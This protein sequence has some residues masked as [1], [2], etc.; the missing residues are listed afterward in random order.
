[1]SPNSHFPHDRLPQPIDLPARF[2]NIHAHPKTQ[3]NDYAQPIDTIS[4]VSQLLEIFEDV[5][6]SDLCHYLYQLSTKG[7]D[8]KEVFQQTFCHFFDRYEFGF[9]KQH[10][11]LAL[12][13]QLVHHTTKDANY[14]HLLVHAFHTLQKEIQG[15][16]SFPYAPIKLKRLESSPNLLLEQY[17]GEADERSAL[18]AAKMVLETGGISELRSSLISCS[19]ENLCDDGHTIIHI[20]Q[21]C[22]ILEKIGT[23]AW[24]NIIYPIIRALVLKHTKLFYPNLFQLS[25]DIDRFKPTINLTCH[26]DKELN[27][28]D[29]LGFAHQFLLESPDNIPSFLLKQSSD[30][31]GT[32]LIHGLFLAACY[33]LIEWHASNPHENTPCA[34][35]VHLELIHPY[36]LLHV[37]RQLFL[38]GHKVPRL[39]FLAT[40]HLFE[41]KKRFLQGPFSKMSSVQKKHPLKYWK[42]L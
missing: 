34:S 10:A 19:L 28:E 31:S 9:E 13:E 2:S 8:L 1:M 11:S 21:A 22:S 25:Q 24:T 17:I 41:N 32:S 36:L 5:N 39:L 16:P 35:E 18:A 37:A 7:W 4:D 38:K 3:D 30:I 27:M 26:D 42:T 15:C 23:Q 14:P 20:Y 29:A 6:A 33:H 12:W 40:H